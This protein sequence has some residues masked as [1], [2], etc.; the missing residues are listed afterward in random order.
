MQVAVV[1]VPSGAT[2]TIFHNTLFSLERDLETETGRE[3][4]RCHHPDHTDKVLED[5]PLG[6][7]FRLEHA[8]R[9]GEAESESTV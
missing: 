2:Q 1:V 6:I 4:S 8:S 9:G 5:N 3:G 7:L